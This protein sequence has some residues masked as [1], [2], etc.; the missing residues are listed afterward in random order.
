MR[1]PVYLP[2]PTSSEPPVTIPAYSRDVL[3][4]TLI[5]L[6]GAPFSLDDFPFYR[7]VYQIDHDQLLFKCG[8]QVAKSTTINNRSITNSIAVPHFR[9]LYVAPTQMQSQVFSTSRVDPALKYSPEIYHRYLSRGAVLNT[10][11]KRFNNGA[12]MRI[13]YASDD[14]DRLRGISADEVD[15]DEVQ[16]IVLDAVVP[17]ANEC[18]ANSRYYYQVYAGTPK[19]MDNGIEVLWQRS[20]QNEWVI[21]C[22]GCNKW[23]A[24]LTTKSLGKHG[25]ICL[26][27]GKLLD[28]RSGQWQAM[29]PGVRLEGYHISQLIL[30]L[31]SEVPR[32]WE[33]LLDKL[34]T[35]PEAKFKNEVLGVSDSI[36][37]RMLS[38]ADLERCCRDYS[39]KE[40][41]SIADFE[42]VLY[43][44]AGVDWSG[45][46]AA[47]FTSRSAVWVWGVLPDGRLKTMF[48][49]VYPTANAVQDVRDIIEVC[50]RWRVRKVAG[51]AGM[52]AI[53][54]AMLAEALGY[55]RV[56]QVQYGASSHQLRWN[57]KDRYMLDKTSA[58]DT[59][60]MKFKN[61]Q[62]FFATAGEMRV[63][64]DD[65]IAEFE[66]VTKQ[67]AG[68][69][70]WT[71]SP[72][73][74][75][76]ALHASVFG[77]VAYQ[78]AS[79]HVQFYPLDAG[80]ATSSS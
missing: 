70:V 10:Q 3:A 9:T 39:L 62:V 12:E 80:L 15:Y 25:V 76:D 50:E 79:G 77:W 46:G 75:D 78:V 23:N 53:A 49:K 42:D 48:Y 16:D 66:H 56:L 38:R 33:I 31:N 4:E 71:H 54:N 18:M 20:T 34:E 65:I 37:S 43:T 28:V 29:N 35:Y 59:L 61:E 27:C 72:H 73:V 68:T 32:R 36:G 5:R 6:D 74:P 11:H 14:A 45:G 55:D 30:P 57:N 52:G 19:S 13:L 63:A 67:G 64:F 8:R 58:I 41:P 22:T 44:V 26:K 40:H 60:M 21:R 7:E 24:P 47:T 51:D 1:G 17:V 69:R 2:P